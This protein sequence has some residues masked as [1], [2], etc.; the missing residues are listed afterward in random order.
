[1]FRAELLFLCGIDPLLPADTLDDGAVAALWDAAIEQMRRAECSGR[2][3]TAAPADL[4]ASE[5]AEPERLFVY[6]REGE[7][8]RRCATPIIRLDLGGRSIWAC[9]ACQSMC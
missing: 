3:V 8:C 5:G 4:E 1:V 7:P 6:G 2:I 9:R